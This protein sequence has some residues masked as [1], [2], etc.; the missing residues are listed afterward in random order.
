[1]AGADVIRF[2][3]PLTITEDEIH[4]AMDIIDEILTEFEAE[5]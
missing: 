2:V 1:M 5:A 4:K 3:P